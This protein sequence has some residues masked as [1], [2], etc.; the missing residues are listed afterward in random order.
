MSFYC[1]CLDILFCFFILRD[2]SIVF[3]DN[4]HYATNVKLKLYEEKSFNQNWALF[5]DGNFFPVMLQQIII[6]SVN[7]YI[8][9][10]YDYSFLFCLS[11]A[12]ISCLIFSC[13]VAPKFPG[14]H[15]PFPCLYML[16]Y[17]YTVLFKKKKKFILTPN[18]WPIVYILLLIYGEYP[19][20]LTTH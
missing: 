2:K 17:M 8:K 5:L 16:L 15:L 7:K 18:F 12:F 1:S 6:K 9:L 10:Q 3:S 20:L 14:V 4:Q 11:L 19:E 13:F